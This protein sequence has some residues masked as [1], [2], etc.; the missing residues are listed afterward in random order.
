MGEKLRKKGENLPKKDCPTLLNKVGIRKKLGL[1]WQAK[2][3]PVASRKETKRRE[4]KLKLDEF[5]KI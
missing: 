4:V 1:E 5:S 3:K 2:I